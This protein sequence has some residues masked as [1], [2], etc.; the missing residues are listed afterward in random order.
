[1]HR[2]VN[3]IRTR[4]RVTHW[5]Q[6]LESVQLTNLHGWGG[7]QVRFE[8]PFSVICGENG[9]GKSTVL[10]AAASL[11]RHPTDR[12]LSFSA[13]KFFPDTPWETTINAEI[14]GEIRQ[15]EERRT[16]RIRKPTRN[17]RP[18]DR[19]MRRVFWYD[20]A[21]TMPKEAVVGY[22]QIAKR[23]TA[24]IAT[25]ELA[26]EIRTYYSAVLGRTYT[27]ARHADTDAAPGRHVG[28]VDCFGTTY[29]QFHQGAGESCA[30]DLLAELQNAPNNS[31][32]LIDEIEAS[33]H[34]SAQRRLVHCLLWLCRTRHF[35]IIATTHS[36]Y[37][38]EELPNEARTLL[39]R[40]EQGVECLPSAASNYALGRMDTHFHPDLYVFVEDHE[41][42]LM[43]A[44]IL[45][46][47]GAD[48]T[49]FGIRPVGP[50]S[51]VKAL[52]EIASR[53]AFHYR[54]ASVVDGDG[55]MPVG[56][57]RLPGTEAPERVVFD[58]VSGHADQLAQ[59]LGL[60]EN[61]VADAVRAAMT[62]PDHHE[63]IGEVARRL[64][65]SSDYVWTTMLR[66]WIRESPIAADIRTFGRTLQ[67]VLPN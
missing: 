62:M 17:W 16:A 44:E 58:T 66:V 13:A 29:S 14:S 32:V 6:Y 30:L 28:V 25:D 56:C 39:V 51:A 48:L 60:Q 19:P 11:Y 55:E 57:M 43:V 65:S 67:S 23:N 18:R 26:P 63:W 50:Y 21:R 46:E 7:Q 42:E 34:P 36:P 5:P 37:V 52:G 9:T 8:F 35:Q 20:I 10:K 64:R 49:R 4:D 27:A 12:A 1:M 53:G 40:T 59:T 38:L 33:L 41:A 2:E 22:A 31:L 61:A 15:G 47:I 54:S 45:R 3:Q 24:E